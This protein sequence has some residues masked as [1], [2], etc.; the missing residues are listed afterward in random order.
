M[1]GK[2]GRRKWEDDERGR[3]EDG[4]EETLIA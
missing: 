1:K 3:G 2:G 4:I